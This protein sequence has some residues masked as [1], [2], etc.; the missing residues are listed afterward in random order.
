MTDNQP[1]IREY[2]K[3][4]K[5]RRNLVARMEKAGCPSTP[6]CICYKKKLMHGIRR[7]SGRRGGR[8]GRKLRRVS[9]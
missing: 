6:Q 5:K 7:S 8:R 1:L 9:G 4:F 3:K 2:A